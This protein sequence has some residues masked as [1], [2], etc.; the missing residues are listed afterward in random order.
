MTNENSSKKKLNIKGKDIIFVITIIILPAISGIFS[1]VIA[2]LI[3]TIIN[4]FGNSYEISFAAS[5]F[6]NTI[7]NLSNV[8]CYVIIFVLGLL[9]L[10]NIKKGS[11]AIGMIAVASVLPTFV[12]IFVSSVIYIICSMVQ[13]AY[14][15][16]LSIESIISIIITIILTAV[17]TLIIF[18]VSV[19]TENR[20][21]TKKI[22]NNAKIV[23]L[24][25]LTAAL[26]VL[27]IVTSLVTNAITVIT[28]QYLHNFTSSIFASLIANNINSAIWNTVVIIIIAAIVILSI[29]VFKDSYAGF[30]AVGCYFFFKTLFL[31]VSNLVTGIIALFDSNAAS[32]FSSIAFYII[33]VLTAI[34]S[35]AAFIGIE[36]IFRKKAQKADATNETMAQ[37]EEFSIPDFESILENPDMSEQTV[38]SSE[39]EEVADTNSFAE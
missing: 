8:L 1:S 20:L 31:S 17:F 18:F 38:L 24:S 14:G 19:L 4:N 39:T 7:F 28:S 36:I 21:G 27:N 13:G 22:N 11:A 33:Y 23:S 34:A 3:V 2:P 29:V 10:K 35:V 25:V 6:S 9:L 12:S 15:T 5:S 26:P 16:A 32:I 30:S 37:T